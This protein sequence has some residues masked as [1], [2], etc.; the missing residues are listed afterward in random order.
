MD[1]GTLWDWH[2]LRLS[3]G[4]LAIGCACC[5]AASCFDSKA[6]AETQWLVF[7]GKE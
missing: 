6:M 1:H 5:E 7:D 4:M 3:A 2:G